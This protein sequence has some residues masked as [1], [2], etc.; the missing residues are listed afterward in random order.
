MPAQKTPPPIR[1]CGRLR[2]LLRMPQSRNQ[3][4]FHVHVLLQDLEDDRTIPLL[5]A[6]RSAG[7]R[8]RPANRAITSSSQGRLTMFAS[9]QC[10]IDRL[11]DLP[12]VAAAPQMLRALGCHAVHDPASPANRLPPAGQETFGLQPM[13]HRIDASF[14]KLQRP[15]VDWRIAWTNSYPYM[16]RRANR[17]RISSSGTPL[18]KSGFVRFVVMAPL[19][20]MVQ[21]IAIANRQIQVEC[22]GPD[23][24]AE[25][26][27]KKGRE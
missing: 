24:M 11:H 9:L 3:F 18:R 5:I 22:L 25:R 26:R 13:Q 15:R 1:D 12:P 10:T 20:L 2:H 17:L 7:G 21:G 4:A 14:A 16:G 6:E 27:S 19:Y 8:P 23:K